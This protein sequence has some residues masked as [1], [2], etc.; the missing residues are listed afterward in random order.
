MVVHINRTLE[1][2]FGYQIKGIWSEYIKLIV[3]TSMN[4]MLVF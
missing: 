1:L 4:L 3:A 2:V